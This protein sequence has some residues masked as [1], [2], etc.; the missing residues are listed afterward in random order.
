SPIDLQDRLHPLA[1]TSLDFVS[2]PKVDEYNDLRRT[3]CD[4]FLAVAAA[5]PEAT[6][7]RGRSYLILYF[8]RYAVD[9]MPSGTLDEDKVLASVQVV[10]RAASNSR[11]AG[12][13]TRRYAS[14][15]RGDI[16]ALVAAVGQ[17]LMVAILLGAVFGDLSEVV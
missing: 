11:L 8:Q 14:I 15:W 9:R 5:T 1:R 7:G 6:G 4:L 3:G 17:S 10:R 2:G 12:I 13:L 16:P